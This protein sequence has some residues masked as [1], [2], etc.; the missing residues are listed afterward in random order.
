[1]RT[2]VPLSGSEP[3]QLKKRLLVESLAANLLRKT[4]TEGHVTVTCH[5]LLQLSL[6]HT[7]HFKGF[8]L[9]FKILKELLTSL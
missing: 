4:A 5:S 7:A 8:R 3:P 1:M 2:A 6:G 9:M